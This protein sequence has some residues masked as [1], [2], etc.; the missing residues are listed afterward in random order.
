MGKFVVKVGITVDI[1]TTAVD[2]QKDGERGRKKKVTSMVI[3]EQEWKRMDLGT[4]GVQYL[5]T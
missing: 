5:G 2:Q 3:S 1:K 4:Q